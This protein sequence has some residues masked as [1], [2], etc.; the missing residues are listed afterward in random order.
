MRHFIDIGDHAT[1]ALADLLDRAAL[2]KKRRRQGIVDRSLAGKT[3][4]MYFEKASLRTRLALDIA[5]SSLGGATVA[6]EAKTPTAFWER[7]VIRDQARVAGRMAEIVALRTYAHETIREFA[8][9]ANAPVVNALSDH[10]H[11][12]QAMADL[13]TLREHFGRLRDLTLVFIGD[14]NNVA[15]SLLEACARTGM[16]FIHSGPPG[17]EL[18]DADYRAAAA[19]CPGSSAFYEPDPVSAAREA[20]CLY[21]DV[22]TSMGHE[23]EADRRRADFSR[24]R[25]DEALLA[26][27]PRTAVAMHCLPAVRG[28]EISDGVLDDPERSLA[29]VQAENRMHFYRGLFPWLLDN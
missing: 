19:D 15:R 29:F 23:E 28:E 26:R 18:P 24:Y 6:L 22:W 27:A 20:D 12:T 21:T 3:L 8:A 4:V 1:D 13:M 17:Y 5:A 11:P 16:R 10:S 9:W 25:V 14:G 2:M 7:E